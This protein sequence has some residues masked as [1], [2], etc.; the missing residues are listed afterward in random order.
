MS[1]VC[2]NSDCAVA[3]FSVSFA[4]LCNIPMKMARPN[5]PENN[6]QQS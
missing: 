3:R 6:V 2:V 5:Q 4:F 1:V